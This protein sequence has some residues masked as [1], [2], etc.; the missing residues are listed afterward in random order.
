MVN[1]YPHQ[2]VSD[3]ASGVHPEVLAKFA[4]VNH[5]H[6]TGY[7][8]D[9]VTREALERFASAFGKHSETFLLFNGTGANVLALKGMLQSHEAVICSDQAHLLVD[10]CGAPEHFVGCK[11]IGVPTRGGKF[12]VEQIEAWL[13]T[14]GGGVHHNQPRVISLA[15]ATERGTLYSLDELRGIGEYARERGLL[16]HLDGARIAN[17]AVALGVEFEDLAEW[18]DVLSFGGTKNGLMMAEALVVLNPELLHRYPYIRKQGM[19]LASKHRFLAAQFLAYF[20]NDLW[21]RNAANANAMARRL[22]GGLTAIDGVRLC[23]PVEINLVFV[24]LPTAW[25]EAL[26]C[27]TPCLA[28]RGEQQSEVRLVTSFDTTVDDIDRFIAAFGELASRH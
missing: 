12:G 22:A 18:A 21:R 13:A 14:D 3:N 8:A 23:E 16:L 15:Q 1:R 4:N 24:Q 5:G 25:L 26:Q 28:W 7:G 27:L 11:L 2:L 17:A 20:D 9:P 19:Q 10:E 6:V